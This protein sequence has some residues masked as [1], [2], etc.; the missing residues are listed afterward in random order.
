MVP[1]GEVGLTLN[2]S[3]TNYVRNLI[4]FPKNVVSQ[5][6]GHVLGDGHLARSHT[7]VLAYFTFTKTVKRISYAW[8]VF[9][10]LEHYCGRLPYLNP[11]FD[12]RKG[13]Y[14]PSVNIMTRSFP[15]LLELHNLFFVDING[16]FVKVILDDLMYYID[17]IA[18]AYWAMDDGASTTKNSG[19]YLH[20]KAFS[21]QETWK[22]AGMLHYQ[23]G[24][25]CT[26]QNHKNQPVIYITAQSMKLFVSIVRPHFHPSMMYK[27]SGYSV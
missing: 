18:L 2:M 12:K 21:F 19:F 14:Y 25:V 1:F 23:F 27:L 26:V 13:V 10:M 9:T 11:G 16:H 4:H 22:L 3:F 5:L 8:H 24:L 17:P 20:T 7:S 6:I 15:F